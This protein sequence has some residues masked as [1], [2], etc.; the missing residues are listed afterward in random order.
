MYRHMFNKVVNFL[1]SS[2]LVGTCFVLRTSRLYVENDTYYG[3]AVR[4]SVHLYLSVTFAHCVEY[5]VQLAL[6]IA[7]FL[8]QTFVHLQPD[9]E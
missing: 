9:L 6:C 5:C 3:S 7:R 4:L 2:V 8:T 1:I